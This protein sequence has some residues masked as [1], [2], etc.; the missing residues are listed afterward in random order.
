MKPIIGIVGR[1][2]IIFN[3]YDVEVTEETYKNAVI[4]S[5]GIPITILPPQNISYNSIAPKDV[6]KLT[7]E[8]MNNLNRVIEV[9]DAIIMPGG[10]KTYGYDYYICN[11]ANMINI[12]ILGIC[13]GM[14]VIV[15]EG[16]NIQLEKCPTDIHKSNQEYSHSIRLDKNSLLYDIIMK[17][18]ILVNSYHSYYVPNSG[19]N[20]ISA[21]SKEDGIIEAI[22]NPN[23]S[24]CIGVQWHPEKIYDENSQK[25]FTYFIEEAKKYRKTK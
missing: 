15:R 1:P 14:Q 22:E 3:K 8:E 20:N 9:C 18:E 7:M 2:G 21:I 25:L 23:S 5:G 13:A 11:Y 24:F 12:P 6:E 4:E 16:S 19:I 10:F 17:E